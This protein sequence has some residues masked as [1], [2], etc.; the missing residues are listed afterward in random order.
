MRLTRAVVRLWLWSVAPSALAGEGMPEPE[1]EE[2]SAADAAAVEIAMVQ[3][4]APGPDGGLPLQPATLLHAPED[5]DDTRVPACGADA[6][7]CLV[8]LPHA[9]TRLWDGRTLRRDITGPPGTWRP[10]KKGRR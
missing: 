10:T 2:V 3:P 1:D 8:A 7:P 9:R 4:P 5:E 6:P